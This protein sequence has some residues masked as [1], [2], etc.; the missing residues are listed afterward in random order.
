MVMPEK[1]N[2]SS[3]LVRGLRVLELIA[4]EGARKGLSLQ[5]VVSTLKINKSNAY[6]YMSTLCD[7]GW[8]ERDDD[9]FHY[10]LGKKSLQLSGS[11]LYHLDLRAIARVY[12]QRLV[13]ETHQTAHISILSNDQILYI[14]KVESNSPIQMRSFAGMVAPLYCTAMGKAILASKPVKLVRELVDGKLLKKTNNT[15]TTIHALITDLEKTIQSGYAFDNEENEEGISCFGAALYGFDNEVIGAIS[16]SAMTQSLD[17][18]TIEALSTK[19][20][21]TASQI[22]QAMGCLQDHWKLNIK[23][24]ESI[25]K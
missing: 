14:D 18:D 6:R 10:R 25:V 9:T 15:L 11:F 2:H 3:T 21:Q 7:H 24:Y 12:L 4:Q 23:G 17:Q 20:R 16:I 8:L 1:N 22:S 13:E 19:V 5:D